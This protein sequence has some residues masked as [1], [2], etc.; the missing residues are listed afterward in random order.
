[1]ILLL[2]VNYCST[3]YFYPFALFFETNLFYIYILISYILRFHIHLFQFKYIRYKYDHTKNHRS[4]WKSTISL[5][6]TNISNLDESFKNEF[7]ILI[8]ISDKLHHVNIFLR[9]NIFAQLPEVLSNPTQILHKMYRCLFSLS[10]LKL[11]TRW[12]AKFLVTSN[13]FYRFGQLQSIKSNLCFQMMLLIVVVQL[14]RRP[15]YE[16]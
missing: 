9:W 2:N 5:I 1:V 10:Q 8:I 7:P 4:Q 14:W 12:Q 16:I 6:F 13:L 15:D 3:S 11:E